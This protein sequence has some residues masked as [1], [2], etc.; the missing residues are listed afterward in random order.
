MITTI[1]FDFGDIFIN[2]EKQRCASQ[3]E[4]LDISLT[5]RLI[6]TQ[7]ELYEKGEISENF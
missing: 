5:N 7:N 2:L 4:K 3:F 6:L 1:I